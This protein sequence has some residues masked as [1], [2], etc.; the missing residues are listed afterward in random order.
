MA[1]SKQRSQIHSLQY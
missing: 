1:G